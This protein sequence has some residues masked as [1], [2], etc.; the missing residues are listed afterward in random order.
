M[1]FYAKKVKKRQAMVEYIII[2]AVIAIAALTVFGFFGDTIKEKV[3]GIINALGGEK[4]GEAS[5]EAS[6]SSK[7][8]MMNLTKDGLNN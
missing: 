6:A 8:T 1:Q 2:V 4:G 7:E 5:A 3:S